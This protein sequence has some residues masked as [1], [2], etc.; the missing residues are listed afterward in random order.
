MSKFIYGIIT[1]YTVSFC[2]IICTPPVFHGRHYRFI[3]E[4]RYPLLASCYFRRSL[5]GVYS[6]L[7]LRSSILAESVIAFM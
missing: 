1:N 3:L 5:L 2:P 7:I 4:L 6:F